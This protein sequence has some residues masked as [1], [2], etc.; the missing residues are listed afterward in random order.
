V[1]MLSWA[2][3]EQGVKSFTVPI[4]QDALVEGNETVSLQLAVPGALASSVARENAT[5]VIIDDDGPQPLSTNIAYLRS[6]VGT[7]NYVPTDTNSLFTVEGTVTTYTNLTV[8]P[9][10]SFF[11]QD[12]TAGI[13][14]YFGNGTNQ[15][16]P[17][18]GDRVRVTAPLTQFRGL[19]ELAPQFTNLNHVVWR[20]SSG[21]PLPTPIA[22]NF[23]D[24]TNV[25]LMEA[26]EGSYVSADKVWIAQSV[27]GTFPT[28]SGD[29]V[30][31]NQAGNTFDL[32]VNS[33]T[34]MAGKPIP[35]GPV[36]ILGVLN[37]YDTTAP[38]TSGYELEPSR[39]A[40]IVGGDSGVVQFVDTN[41][42][43]L[44]SGPA[45]T[46]SASRTGAN[47]GT[48]NISFDTVNGT[49]TAGTDYV[50]TNGVLS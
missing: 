47:S 28:N 39:Y 23:A 1:D 6:L 13:D 25:A 18:A 29:V 46:L 48:V 49:A 37:Q 21:N 35:S 14:V 34:D 32:F 27:G 16:L 8:N 38:Y 43:V 4:H 15:A 42:T 3:G 2:D 24:K 12:A 19:L 50:A 10:V 7:T 26:T 45:I 22:L 30:V 5:L 11:M 40:D 20:L 41:F 36:T 17:V 44:E 31:T 33:Y 9:N